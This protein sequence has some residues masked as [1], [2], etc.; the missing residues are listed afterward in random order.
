MHRPLV[1]RIHAKS[2]ETRVHNE[3]LSVAMRV[4]R[5]Y[6]T[7]DGVGVGMN[8]ATWLKCTN[9]RAISKSQIL[10]ASHRTSR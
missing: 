5:L 4:N 7:G 9:T 8:Q 1:P 3:T 2:T 6:L 10:L